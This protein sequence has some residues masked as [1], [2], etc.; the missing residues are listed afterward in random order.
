MQRDDAVL[1]LLA[2]C[3]ARWAGGTCA[4][5]T[6]HAVP[7]RQRWQVLV[8]DLPSP[9]VPDPV[10][11][12]S[13]GGGVVGQRYPVIRTERRR[14]VG[15]RGIMA[16][17]SAHPSTPPDRGRV[18]AGSCARHSPPLGRGPLGKGEY[19]KVVLTVAIGGGVSWCVAPVMAAGARATPPHP[20]SAR[21]AGAVGTTPHDTRLAWHRG[22]CW[23]FITPRHPAPLPAYLIPVGPSARRHAIPAQRTQH[24]VA[25]GWGWD[26]H[27]TRPMAN[28]RGAH[29]GHDHG[30]HL[31]QQM[32][33]RG[34]S[35]E[36]LEG[37]PAL[38]SSPSR[39]AERTAPLSPAP[40]PP[41]RGA[42]RRPCSRGG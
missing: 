38:P 13:A 8:G 5:S 24:K 6:I 10:V 32:R 14:V 23:R 42:A 37:R 26:G 29:Y 1:P 34:R 19:G 39:L 18:L 25:R 16:G 9:H 21:L 7:V 27:A 28:G 36:K 11:M 40:R 41:A 20:A 4:R 2:L 35:V 22:R 17:A 3:R 15:R 12:A 31:V 30:V 33:R